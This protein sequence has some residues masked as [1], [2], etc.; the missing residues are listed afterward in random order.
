[1]VI[2]KPRR[3]RIPEGLRSHRELLTKWL[4]TDGKMSELVP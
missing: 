1:M 4:T 2:T 3:V